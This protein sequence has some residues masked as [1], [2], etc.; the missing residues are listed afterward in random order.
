MSVVCAQL[1][2]EFRAGRKRVRE[3]DCPQLLTEMFAPLP[4]LIL[5]LAI[6][7]F[8]LLPT[9]VNAYTWCQP[10][11]GSCGGSWGAWR[12]DGGS[13]CVGL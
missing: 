8:A 5:I 12:W 1:R 2:Y 9:T 6:A 4:Y 3:R 7:T 10:A 11:R 13:G